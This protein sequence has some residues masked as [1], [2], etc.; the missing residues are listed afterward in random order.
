M[1]RLAAIR[2]RR[3]E[4]LREV[5]ATRLHAMEALASA[6]K[7]SSSLSLGMAAGQILAGRGW[8]R[9]AVLVPA[10]LMVL[11]RLRGGGDRTSP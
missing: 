3:G 10:A 11:R 4:V 8:F 5:Q 7:W 6:R 2:A 9:A 1:S